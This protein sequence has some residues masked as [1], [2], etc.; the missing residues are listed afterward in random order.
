MAFAS[1][2]AKLVDYMMSGAGVVEILA[3]YGIKG[4]DAQAVKSY[5]GQALKA[6]SEKNGEITKKELSDVI[7]K[8]PVTGQ[9]ANVRKELQLLLDTSE[10]QL[11]KEDVVKAVNHIIYLANRHGKSFIVTCSDCVNDSLAKNG[12]KFTVETLKNSKNVELLKNVI[13]NKPAELTNF[14]SSRMRRLG[15]GDYSKVTPTL[16]SPTE[17]KSLALFLALAESGT[18][19]QKDFIAAIKKI[20]TSN[21]KVNIIDPSNPHKFWRELADDMS[22]ETMKGW[23]DTLNE[24]AARR[25][26]DG[27]TAEEAFFRTLKDKADKNPE[28]KKQYETLKTKRCFF[29]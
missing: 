25:S 3:K 24:V 11:K 23:T 8:L 1:G 17:E 12:F 14:I 20:S 4:D 16:V 22:P 26:K 9:D 21:G 6:L 18:K 5:V 2:T 29:K 28:L 27:V 15:M 7:S 19:E 10:G 13:P